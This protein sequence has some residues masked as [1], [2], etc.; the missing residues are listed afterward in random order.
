M[1]AS[2]VRLDCKSSAVGGLAVAGPRA[3]DLVSRLTDEDVS[4]EAFPFLTVRD[5]D[6]R[7]LRAT[8]GRISYTGELGFEIWV[9]MDYLLALY[10]MLTKAGDDLD[11][12]LFGG[13]TLQSLR[14]E[15]SFG[16]FT[17]EYTSDYT[18]FEAGLGRFV[19]FKKGDFI[20]RDAAL[21]AREKGPRWKL[22]TFVVD[23]DGVDALAN[24]PIHHDGKVVG[25][26]TSGGYGHV[27]GKSI[28]L[29]YVPTEL[30]EAGNEFEIVI[31]GDPR[32][33]TLVGEPLYD[34]TGERM[35][36]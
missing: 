30:A 15:K 20:G 33:A 11:L 12:T 7:E 32:P 14:L 8:V 26:V 2:G 25:W 9:G 35:R 34:P 27:V 13:R 36:G 10:E 17:R 23:D 24:E 21:E 18:P 3:R 6:L 4:A 16:A 5:I 19:S 1:P 31:L 28:A 29:G 22:S